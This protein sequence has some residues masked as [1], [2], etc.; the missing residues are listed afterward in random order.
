MLSIAEE[1]GQYTDLMNYKLGGK[2]FMES[3][4]NQFKNKFDFV[5]AGS[6][7]E[8]NHFDEN[9][10]QQMLFSVKNGGYLIFSAQYSY[11]GNF[12]YHETLFQLEKSGRIKFVEDQIFSRFDKLD[13]VI[14]KFTKTPSKIYVYQKTEGDSMMIANRLRKPSSSNSTALTECSD[15]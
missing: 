10:F 2:D 3:F 1:K 15:F 11:I 7:I 13:R 8:T 14:G 12:S 5:V 4:P 9:L 6:L